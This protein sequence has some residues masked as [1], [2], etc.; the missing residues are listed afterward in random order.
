MR[1]IFFSSDFRHIKKH[2]YMHKVTRLSRRLE[3]YINH[4]VEQ[5]CI[6]LLGKI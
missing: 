6:T 1:L 4:C 3:R 2:T 5:S